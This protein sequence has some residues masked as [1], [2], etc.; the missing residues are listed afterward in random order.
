MQPSLLQI[1]I[2]NATFAF[3]SRAPQRNTVAASRTTKTHDEGA[4]LLC[5]LL[6]CFA[7]LGEREKKQSEVERNT[8]NSASLFANSE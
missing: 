8:N 4:L 6:S 7:C 2:N 1:K 3:V 5:V